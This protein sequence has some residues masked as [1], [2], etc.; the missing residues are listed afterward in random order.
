[1]FSL[2]VISG[3]GLVN[4]SAC[5]TKHFNPG[6]IS[7]DTILNSSPELRTTVSDSV[8]VRVPQM[9]V[10]PES[11]YVRLENREMFAIGNIYCVSR[12]G[13]KKK[14]KEN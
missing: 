13:K 10:A 3:L 11:L 1:M 5:A 14:G 2:T 7:G 6:E 8:S 9:A 4:V 12:G